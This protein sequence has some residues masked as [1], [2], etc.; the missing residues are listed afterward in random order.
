MTCPCLAYH[1]LFKHIVFL[2]LPLHLPN[3]LWVHL[4]WSLSFSCRVDADFVC[5]K[6]SHSRPVPIGVRHE[7]AKYL[8]APT[9]HLYTP[10]KYYYISISYSSESILWKSKYKKDLRCSANVLIN[11]RYLKPLNSTTQLLRHANSLTSVL[12]ISFANA[13]CNLAFSVLFV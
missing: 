9:S 10:L 13:S 8:L 4:L 1:L 2:V 12:R 11:R 3:K 7:E 6:I 5:L